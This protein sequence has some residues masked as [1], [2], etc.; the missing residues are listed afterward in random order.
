MS[1]PSRASHKSIDRARLMQLISREEEKFATER[2]K[3]AALYRRA[4]QSLLGVRRRCPRRAFH[5]C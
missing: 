1:T 4:Q 3:S 5:R 2:P